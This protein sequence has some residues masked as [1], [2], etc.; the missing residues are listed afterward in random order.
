MIIEVDVQFLAAFVAVVAVAAASWIFLLRWRDGDALLLKMHHAPDVY[1]FGSRLIGRDM[2]R[3]LALQ[4]YT[5][6]DDI[7]DWASEMLDPGKDPGL[8]ADQ[9]FSA[10]QEANDNGH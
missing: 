3:L 4:M 5:M 7:P 6:G 8:I 9:E 10:L 2:K 1:G